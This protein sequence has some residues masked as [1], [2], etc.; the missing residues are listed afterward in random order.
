MYYLTHMIP[1]MWRFLLSQYLKVMG[2]C[3][4]AFIAVLL[5]TRLDDI[6][7]FASLSP[8][9]SA[10]TLFILFQIPYILP[11]VIPIACLISAILLVQRLS[12]THELTAFRS[13][14]IALKDFLT[15]ILFSAALIATLDLYIVSEL[16]TSSHLQTG[17]WREQLRSVNPLLLLR[18]KHLMKVKGG[19]YDTIG[20]SKVGERAEHVVLAMPNNNRQR[21]SLFLAD[22][23]KTNNG[24]L[25]GK[26]ITLITSIPANDNR[27]FDQLFIE[28]MKE[29]VTSVEDFSQVMQQNVWNISDDHLKMDLLLAKLHEEKKVYKLAK[30]NH[31]PKNELTIISHNLNRAYSEIIRRFS[32][33]LAAFTFSLMGA[34]FGISISRHQS[35]KG[36]FYVIILAGLYL[37]AFFIA[38]GLGQYLVLSALLY[39]VPH[40]IIILLSVIV[41][42]RVGKGIEGS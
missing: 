21:I 40:L 18:N 24:T 11:I 25:E 5:T 27:T 42:K 34:S 28:N 37:T 3:V 8:S 17:I 12:K 22:E 9:I 33:A 15:P 16:S 26:G 10:V 38:K 29:T 41:L 39:T 23:L 4:V 6:A 32:V 36:I 19:Y 2:F 7:H 20:T 14:G 13:C 35:I 30:A 31:A 1:I